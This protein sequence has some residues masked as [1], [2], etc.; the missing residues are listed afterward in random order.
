M[1][2]DAVQRKDLAEMGR[3]WGSAQG[4]AAGRMQGQELQQR[5]EVIQIYLNHQSYRVLGPAPVTPGK[6]VRRAYQ[7]ELTRPNRCKASFPIELVQTGTGGWLVQNV[8]L[9]QAGNPARPCG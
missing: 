2:M 7:I 5:L 3:L 6:A 8:N 1:F 9:D 4:A